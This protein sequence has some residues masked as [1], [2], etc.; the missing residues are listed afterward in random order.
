MLKGRRVFNFRRYECS[1]SPEYATRDDYLEDPKSVW[2]VFF[3]D[4]ISEAIVTGRYLQ[5]NYA[6]GIGLNTQLARWFHQRL[7]MYF[8]QASASHFYSISLTRIVQDSGLLN[9]DA[10]KDKRRKIERALSDLENS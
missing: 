10:M 6:V 7:S 8:K 9:V 5:Y 2:L 4:L 3:P 1:T